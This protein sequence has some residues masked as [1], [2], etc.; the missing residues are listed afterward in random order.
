MPDLRAKQILDKLSYITVASVTVDGLP[1][2]SP[3]FAVH[4]NDFNFY[5]GTHKQSQKAKN[6]RSNPNVFLVIYDST[7]PAGSGEGVYIQ[8]KT[9]TISDPKE[10]ATAHKLLW[11]QHEAPYWKLEEFI[12]PSPLVLFKV[13]PEKVWMNDEGEAGGHYIDTRKEVSL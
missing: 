13:V 10:I 7:V 11:D 9:T 8:A 5:F 12:E 1:W 2:N 6:I 4:D 3:V